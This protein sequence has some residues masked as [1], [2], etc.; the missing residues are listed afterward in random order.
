MYVGA[1]LTIS[2]SKEIQEDIADTKVAIAESSNSVSNQENL[3][4]ASSVAQWNTN[5]ELADELIR[6]ASDNLGSRYRAG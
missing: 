4:I 6:M 3:T 1:I 5:E 2:G